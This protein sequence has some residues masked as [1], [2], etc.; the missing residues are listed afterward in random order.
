MSVNILQLQAAYRSTSQCFLLDRIDRQY[1]M[2]SRSLT[3]L[4]NNASKF[5]RNKTKLEKLALKS[6]R[7]RVSEAWNIYLS[8]DP[9]W[10]MPSFFFSSNVSPKRREK[11]WKTTPRPADRPWQTETGGGEDNEAFEVLREKV[12]SNW[13]GG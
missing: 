2:Q 11:R 5:N 12:F 7:F 8:T 13:M 9:A 4:S 1:N 6:E 3:V 10:Q